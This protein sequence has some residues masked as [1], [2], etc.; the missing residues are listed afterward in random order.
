MRFRQ[1]EEGR[2]FEDQGPLHDVAPAITFEPGGDE[3]VLWMVG[4]G[5]RIVCEVRASRKEFFDLLGQLNE[6][7]G[8]E[9]RNAGGCYEDATKGS[10]SHG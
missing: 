7:I 6:V 9:W 3:A 10:Q 8:R 2:R 1:H 4:E 5:N